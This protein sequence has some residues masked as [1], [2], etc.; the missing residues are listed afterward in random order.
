[1]KGSSP[2]LQVEERL[3]AQ[4]KAARLSLFLQTLRHGPE[5]RGA[6]SVPLYIPGEFCSSP[7]IV[8]GV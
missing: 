5:Y 8:S 3:P 7:V 2:F 4:M 1:M 6:E